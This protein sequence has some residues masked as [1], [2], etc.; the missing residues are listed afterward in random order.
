MDYDEKS[1]RGGLFD[2]DPV[3]DVDVDELLE[4]A[5]G[6]KRERLDQELDRIRE[7]LD[8]RDTIHEEIVDELEFRVAVYS[9]KL[10]SLYKTS[11]GKPDEKRLRLKNRIEEFRAQLR[12]E[13]R[14]HWQ[15]V[16]ELEEVRRDVLRELEE[17]DDDYLSE[18][19]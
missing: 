10:R 11:W 19:L 12:R 18:F 14:E 2:R 4:Q 17:M 16:Q 8:G 13:S 1:D 5:R 7:Q 6:S 3:W 15:D 9:D